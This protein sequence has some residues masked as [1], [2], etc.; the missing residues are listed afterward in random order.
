VP[1]RWDVVQHAL[2]MESGYWLKTESPGLGI[3]VNELEAAKHPFRQEPFATSVARA[4]DGAI[5]DW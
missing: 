4:A 2:K 5:L 1:W 3:E